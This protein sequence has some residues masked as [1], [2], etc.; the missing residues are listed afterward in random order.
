MASGVTYNR[1]GLDADGKDIEGEVPRVRE[2]VLLPEL[3]EQRVE[4]G[5]VGPIDNVVSY[6]SSL[7]C[8]PSGA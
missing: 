4:A 3:G 7:P 2:R 6:C 8:Q 1:D 5:D